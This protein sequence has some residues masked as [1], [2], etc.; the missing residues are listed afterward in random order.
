MTLR[1][2]GRCAVAAA[3]RTEGGGAILCQYGSA[4]YRMRVTS[5]CGWRFAAA[6]KSRANPTEVIHGSALATFHAGTQLDPPRL[7]SPFIAAT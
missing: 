4:A 5:S 1:L 2:R 6:D 7:M 3:R